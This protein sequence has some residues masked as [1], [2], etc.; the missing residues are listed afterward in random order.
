[1][2]DQ[3]SNRAHALLAPSNAS[4]WL[5][6]PPSAKLEDAIPEK[7]SSSYAEEGT[8][9]HEISELELNL[10]L[11]RIDFATYKAKLT[12]KAKS[13]YFGDAMVEEVD[14][15]V[16][17]VIEQIDSVSK[18]CEPTILIEEK[19]DLT[20][21][22]P[23]GFGS[24]DCIIIGDGIMYVTDL[25]YGKGVKVS[26]QENAQLKLYSLGAYFKYQLSYDIT[27]IIMTIVQPRLNWIDS[28]SMQPEDLMDWAENVVKPGAALAFT[29][30]GQT[31]AGEHCRFCKVAAKCKTLAAHNQSLAK[32]EF[33][34]P[35]L[36]TDDE[37]I[38]VMEHTDMLV[39]WANAANEYIYQ[40]AVSG[41]QFKG[42]KLVEGRSNRKIVDE[43]SA[44]MML[45]LEGLTE[46]EYLNKKLKGIT[47]LEKLL[48]KS[49]FAEV[50]GPYV[51]KPQ[52]K[53][54]LVPEDDPRPAF[55]K[56]AQDDFTE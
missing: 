43:E 11:L 33:Q 24:N 27:E 42:Y 29:G 49:A 37:L 7:K 28:F 12:E 6:C 54:A 19:V 8:L 32:F 36:L 35:H 46:E 21:Y 31:K 16:S 15:Y 22:V 4:R 3:H 44:I 2:A 38:E 40:Q 13:S 39:S 10:H 47:E 26:A 50:I 14:K 25:K 1:M 23:D 18:T 20:R 41:K 52:G 56:S 51:V 17:Y 30:E 48:G 34:D 45:D 5:A 9:A 53:P 55:T